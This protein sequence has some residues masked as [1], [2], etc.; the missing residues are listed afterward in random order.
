MQPGVEAIGVAQGAQVAPGFD[1]G[2]LDGVLRG[3]PV[4]KDPARDRVQAVV[5]GAREGIECLVVAPLCANDELGRHRCPS[6]RRGN[7][8]RYRLWRLGASNPSSRLWRGRRQSGAEVEGGISARNLSET[9]A[10]RTIDP[11]TDA[12]TPPQSPSS[13]DLP[14]KEERT[15][16][17]ETQPTVVSLTD[18]AATKLRE[19]TAEETNPNIGLRVYVYSGGCS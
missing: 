18:A 15:E 6:I 12:V 11:S 8:P 9:V 13:T 4:A 10:E 1:E 7:V 16:M 19:L 2:I 17:M 3:I 5:C 14:P